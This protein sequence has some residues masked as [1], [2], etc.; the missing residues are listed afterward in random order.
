MALTKRNPYS[1]TLPSSSE[2]SSAV[3]A[4][5]TRAKIWANTFRRIGQ[6]IRRERR[7]SFLKLSP[8]SRRNHEVDG[9]RRVR[10]A[11]PHFETALGLGEAEQSSVLSPAATREQL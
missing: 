4:P 11:P 2:H 8:P 7:V 5:A 6:A 1:E 3:K 10:G 9:N